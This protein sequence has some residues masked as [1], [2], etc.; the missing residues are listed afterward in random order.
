MAVCKFDQVKPGPTLVESVVLTVISQLAWCCASGPQAANCVAVAVTLLTGCTQ[1]PF[2][3]VTQ[4]PYHTCGT[5]ELPLVSLTQNLIVMSLSL[6]SD[7]ST[8][9]I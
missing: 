4:P 6:M 3:L 1:V 7:E 8:F 2:A 9:L 5:T